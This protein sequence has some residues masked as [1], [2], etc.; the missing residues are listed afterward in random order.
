MLCEADTGMIAHIA[1]GGWRNKDRILARLFTIV[2]AAAFAVLLLGAPRAQSQNP[3]AVEGWEGF[4]TRNP[5]NKFDRCVLYNRTIERLNASPY[6]MLGITRHAAG[7]VG[8][9]IFFVPGTLTRGANTSVRLNIDRHPLSLTGDVLSDFHVNVAGPLEP[10][11]VAAMRDAK[12]IEAVVEGH[13][14]R[15]E[16]ANVDAVLGA[17]AACVRANAR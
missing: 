16:V 5:D 11:A 17:L 9:L 12:T 15:F 10:N 2:A 1:G 14:I 7:G 13:A 3:V 4:A 8:L 6:G